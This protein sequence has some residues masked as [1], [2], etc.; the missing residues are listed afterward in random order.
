MQVKPNGMIVMSVQEYG[1]LLWE[2]ERRAMEIVL[3]G[4][5]QDFMRLALE[6]NSN[7]YLHNSN[8]AEIIAK[9]LIERHSADIPENLH[10]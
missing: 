5:T 6:H 10:A 9:E 8:R 1:Q 7:I 2:F 4:L 3:A